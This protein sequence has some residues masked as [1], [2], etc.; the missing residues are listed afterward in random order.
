SSPRTSCAIRWCRRSWTRTTKRPPRRDREGGVPVIAIQRASRAAHIP[1]DSRIRRWAREALAVPA[2]VTIRYVAEREG[3]RLNGEFRKRDH[4]T[5]VL[6]F[7]Y[8]ARP[9]AGD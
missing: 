3:R 9:L 8:E 5:N 6:T 7:V 4:A 2:E 1:A